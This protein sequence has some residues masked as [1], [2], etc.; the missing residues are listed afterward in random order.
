MRNFQ[1]F[2]MMGLLLVLIAYTL[3]EKF[4]ER[5]KL[6]E[7]AG[8]QQELENLNIVTP[9]FFE[10]CGERVPLIEPDV[11]E[12]IDRELH[13]YV[14]WK[15]G[16][17]MILKRAN[18]WLPVIEQILKEEGLPDDLKYLVIVESGLQNL[19]SPA[20]AAGFWQMMEE[21][22]RTFGLTI[23]E[24]VDER[25]DPIK[26]TRAA[27]KYLKMAHKTLGSWTLAAASYNLG[28]GGMERR[29]ERQQSSSYFEMHFNQETSQ[30]LYKVLAAK[31]VIMNA[32]KYKYNV[33]TSALYNR[34]NLRKVQID[35]T[36]HDLVRLSFQL[37]TNYKTLLDYNPWIRTT[38]LTISE[39]TPFFTFYL[40]VETP[41]QEVEQ[42]AL[43]EL[44]LPTEIPPAGSAS[45]TQPD[46]LRK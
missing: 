14:H 41:G 42:V 18:K 24:E 5:K 19:V 8:Y 29:I 16:M 4:Q 25:Y 36:I 38:R 20:G 17:T 31:E 7:I 12:R 39:K 34:E 9:D 10:F 43:P 2:I 23:N 21:S 26:S 15:A 1:T 32:D 44:E 40:P 6:E 28:I 33:N 13:Y 11:R 35:S 22:G 3:F 45:I 27:C 37:G 30:Y 46:D